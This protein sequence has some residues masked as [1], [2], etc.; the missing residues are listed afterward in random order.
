MI[1][2]GIIE[3][4]RR[5]REEIRKQVNQYLDDGGEIYYADYGESA[6][7]KEPL[8]ADYKKRLMKQIN[9]PMVLYL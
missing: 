1:H 5:Q 4:K 3:A 6:I 8:K 2:S 7:P 9:E